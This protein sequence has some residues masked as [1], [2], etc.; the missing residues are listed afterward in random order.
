MSA[1]YE[2]VHTDAGFTA[3]HI[4][5]GREIMSSGGQVYARRAGARHA[6]ELNARGIVPKVG[7]QYLPYVE[8]ADG[9]IEVRQVD[10][11]ARAAS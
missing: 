1:F 10:E 6:I 4:V 5:N 3:R 9:P 8:T 2:L 11:R 7:G